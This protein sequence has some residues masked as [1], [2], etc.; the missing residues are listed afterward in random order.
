MVSCKNGKEI[1]HLFR[2]DYTDENNDMDIEM[3]TEISSKEKV[4]ILF[5]V[6][7]TVSLILCL[8]CVSAH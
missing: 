7:I 6:I 2:P 8:W 5:S 3:L 4:L 1:A